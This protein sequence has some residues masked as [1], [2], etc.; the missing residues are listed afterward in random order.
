MSGLTLEELAQAKKLPVDLLALLG[1]AT[2]R[3][4]GRTCVRI[5][6][7]DEAGNEVAVRYRHAIA[8][9]QEKDGRFSWQ[10]GTRIEHLYGAERLPAARKAGWVLVVEGESDCWTAWHYG[11]PAV[12]IPGKSTWKPHMAEKLAGL[13]IYVWQEPGAEDFSERVGRDLPQAKVIIAPAAINDISEAH[14]QGRDVPA[15]LQELKTAAPLAATVIPAQATA[16]R[17][18]VAEEASP[19]PAWQAIAELPEAPEGA[20]LE[21]ALRAFKAACAPLDAIATT[22]AAYEAQ[23]ILK[24]R[25]VSAPAERVRAALP[26]SSSDEGDIVTGKANL[27]TVLADPEPWPEEV[28]SALLLD[29]LSSVLRRYVVLPEGAAEAVALWTLYSHCFDAFDVAPILNVTSPTKRCG[30]TR[31]QEVAACIAPRPLQVAN[32]TSA[33]LFRAVEKYQPILLIDESDRSL[34]DDPELNGIIDA[35]HTRDSA[36]VVR[37]VG[38]DYEPHVF[39]VWCPKVIVGIGRQLGTLEDRSIIVNLQRRR[40]NEP[41]ERFRTRDKAKLEPL[42]RRCARWAEDHFEELQGSDPETPSFGGNDRA[43]DN[44]YPLLAVADAAGGSWPQ[45]ARLAAQRLLGSAAEETDGHGVLLLGDLRD[46]FAERGAERLRTSE[47][48]A[49]LHSL[50]ERPWGD[51]RHGKPLNA[52]ALA[53]LLKSFKVRSRK[54]RFDDVPSSV[55]CY[56]LEDLKDAFS[57]WTPAQRGTS[58]TCLQDDGFEGGTLPQAVPAQ[59]VPLCSPVPGVPGLAAEDAPKSSESSL[60]LRL[61]EEL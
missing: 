46:L 39:S 25:H 48:L 13:D 33:A 12:G 43:A 15:L 11:L 17:S 55:H 28:D 27:A 31:L 2:E 29:E 60:P 4:N 26:C 35:G 61:V 57:R 23:R 42:R 9:G 3:V 19:G 41:V 22:T 30:K 6:Y 38:D 20:L 45:R 54:R 52:D 40:A 16:Q 21:A 18:D 50:E 59:K 7:L 58:G 32:I 14:L 10:P 53:R 8:A 24:E 34:R 47:L 5:P 36:H 1:C 51:Y 37:C 49:A 44:W 56:L